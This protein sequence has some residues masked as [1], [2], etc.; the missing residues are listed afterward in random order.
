VYS[1][2]S[3]PLRTFFQKMIT[4]CNKFKELSSTW[5]EFQIVLSIREKEM[6]KKF[7]A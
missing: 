3:N 2:I 1:P 4:N 6:Q 5:V 7:E